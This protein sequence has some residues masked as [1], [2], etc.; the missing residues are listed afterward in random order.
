MIGAWVATVSSAILFIFFQAKGIYTGDSGDLVTAAAVAGIPHPPGYPLYTA[1]GWIVSQIIPFYSVSW[2]VT[3]LSSLPHAI[4]IGLVYTIIH[5]NTKG[6]VISALFGS[7]LLATNYLF[8]LYSITPEVFALFDMFVIILWFLLFEW[9]RTHS[10][11]VLYVASFVFGLSLTHHHIMLFLVPAIVYFLWA[12]KKHKRPRMHSLKE[13]VLCVA[14]GLLGLV[15]YLY[16]PIAAGLDPIINWDRA[17][18]PSAFWRLISRA[19]YGTFV[20][21]GSFGQTLHERWLA[22]VAYGTFVRTDW[23]IIGVILAGMG[24]VS[25]WKNSRTRFWGF[26]L[27]MVFTGPAFFFY[28]SFPLASRF[29]LG[30]YER[31][32]LPGY[33]LLSVLCGIGLW[34][35]QTNISYIL[36]R[37]ANVKKRHFVI[38]LIGI[39][40]MTY[41]LTIAGITLWRFWGIQEDKTAENL[42]RDILENTPKNAILLLSQDTALFTTQYVRYVLGVRP[43]TVVI[44]AARLSVPDYQIVLKKHF[45][46]LLLPQVPQTEFL[47]AFVKTNT[48]TSTR[49]FSNINLPIGEGWYWVPRGL[50]YEAMPFDE[51]P[52]VADMYETSVRFSQTMHDPLAGILSRYPHLMLSDVLDVYASGNIA[53]GKTLI[54]ADRWKEAGEIFYNATRFEGDTSIVEAYEL[55]GLT[56]LYLKDCTGALRSFQEA[57]KRSFVSSPSHLRL[58]S[59]TYGECLGDQKRA[60]EL[61]FQYENL[62]KSSEQSLE[63][64]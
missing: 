39:V 17:V 29:T 42:G 31:F 51:L 45:P 5:R 54:R 35:I 53:L 43:D 11:R 27:A 3:L 10:V 23:T 26:V 18:S 8:F 16:V 46:H 58:E 24:F 49:V 30:T 28:A 6:N 55:L 64:L 13:I 56:Q 59:I 41:P 21:G 36:R 62:R 33:I 25:W 50:L 14:F 63:S 22:V 47:P 57:K 61:F 40:C 48:S 38:L 7:L 15:A 19:D 60:G 2:R 9:Q 44:H 32:L 4:V 1:L 34:E 37:Y 52:E 12:N 20:S